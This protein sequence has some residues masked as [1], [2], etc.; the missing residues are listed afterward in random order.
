M[1]TYSH[2]VSSKR[3]GTW[4][5]IQANLLFPLFGFGVYH[6]HGWVFREPVPDEVVLV[7]A[8]VLAG[9]VAVYNVLGIA[10]LLR[11]RTFAFVVDERQVRCASPLPVHPSYAVP[12]E[13][14]DAVL[15]DSAS[16]GSTYSIKAKDG[17]EFEIPGGYGNDVPAVVEALR[18][19][20]IP[21]IHRTAASKPK[22]AA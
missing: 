21:F 14:V 20:N 13:S 2:T 7:G 8:L 11:N 4:Q 15:V 5:L 6:L 18:S 22:K 3:H 9:C 10:N 17:R 12:V 1:K 16:E 19:R